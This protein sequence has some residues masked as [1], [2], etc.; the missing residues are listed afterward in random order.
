[1]NKESLRTGSHGNASP[2]VSLLLLLSSYSLFSSQRV[3]TQMFMKYGHPFAQGPP[4][5]SHCSRS[6]PRAH[7][8]TDKILHHPAS[9]YFFDPFSYHPLLI[10]SI[11][12]FLVYLL[13]LESAKMLLPQGL[14]TCCPLCLEPSSP[15]IHIAYSSLHPGLCSKGPA[16]SHSLSPCP[17]LYHGAVFLSSASSEQSHCV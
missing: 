15:N 10:H 4:V 14:C 1:M 5:A 3:V 9:C 7:P 16:Q 8:M 11:P 6:K 12:A 13:F 2:P 17:A